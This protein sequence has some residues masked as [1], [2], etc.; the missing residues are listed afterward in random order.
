MWTS[1]RPE[2]DAVP[3]CEACKQ[4]QDVLRGME[5]QRVMRRQQIIILSTPF[6]GVAL[7]LL[8]VYLQR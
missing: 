8:I 7:A 5:F 1:T 2:L 4:V 3:C 6:L